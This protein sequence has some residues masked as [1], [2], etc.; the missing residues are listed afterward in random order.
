MKDA[1]ALLAL[2]TLLLMTPKADPLRAAMPQ[3]AAAGSSE[4]GLSPMT[5]VLLDQCQAGIHVGSLQDILEHKTGM[6]SNQTRFPFVITQGF[7]GNGNEDWPNTY[8][9]PVGVRT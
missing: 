4:T 2:G 5:L 3:A 9:H 1:L 8:R 7:L 6:E